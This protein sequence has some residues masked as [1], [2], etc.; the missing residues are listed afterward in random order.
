[1][2]VATAL[3]RK[4][5]NYTIVMLTSLCINNPVHIDAYLL[6][7]EL[8]ENDIALI[9]NSL[10]DY[11]VNIIPMKIDSHI[12][13]KK[14]PVTKI[15]SIEMYFRLLLSDLLPETVEKILYLDVDI[16]VNKDIS[17]LYNMYLSDK[18]IAA[19]YDR[20]GHGG[21]LEQLSDKQKEMFLKIADDKPFYFNSGVLLLD[22]TSIRKQKITFDTY[23]KAMYDWNFE[24]DAPDQDIL[25]YVFYGKVKYVPWQKYDFFTLLASNYGAHKKDAEN[26][27]IL[28]Y[29][30]NCKPWDSNSFHYDIEEIWWNYAKSSN[31]Y[32]A[33]ADQYITQMTK[34]TSLRDYVQDL[35]NQ[36]TMQKKKISELNTVI[37]KQKE[38]IEQLLW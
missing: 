31:V 20:N 10:K 29:S 35:A 2:N 17:E 32:Y 8:S 33:L 36:Y 26:A 14:M 4:Y 21:S 7:C 3:N 37:S 11:D 18:L 15:W 16:I 28:H 5:I 25:N 27:Y 34:D 24:M 22:I 30:S 23:L 19:A 1:M 9:T 12:F 38:I 6:H 13:S